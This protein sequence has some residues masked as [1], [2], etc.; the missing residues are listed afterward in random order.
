MGYSDIIR[1]EQI[2]GALVYVLLDVKMGAT[3]LFPSTEYPQPKCLSDDRKKEY[4]PQYN[5]VFGDRQCEA[6]SAR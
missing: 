1:S 6:F 2:T 4:T 3:H 5:M